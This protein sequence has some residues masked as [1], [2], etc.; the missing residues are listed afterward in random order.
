MNRLYRPS[1][2]QLIL[3][4]TRPLSPPLVSAS[5]NLFSCSLLSSTLLCSTPSPHHALHPVPSPP[6]AVSLLDSYGLSRE[7]MM[8]TLK[9]MQFTIEK[10]SVLVDAYEKIETSVKVV[11]C[12]PPL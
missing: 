3:T 4:Q 1:P 6:Q 7:D 10:D 2:S 12:V 5:Y 9:E 8:E 11:A